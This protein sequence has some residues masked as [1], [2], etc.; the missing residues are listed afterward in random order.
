[1]ASPSGAKLYR[2][3]LRPFLRSEEGARVEQMR[4]QLIRDRRRILRQDFGAGSL[5]QGADTQ[6][7]SVASLA[8][9]ASSPRRKGE[10]LL[11]L[12]RYLRPRQALE[13]GSHLGLS[14]A[15]LKLGHPAMALI[16]I[17]GDPALGALAKEHW[18]QLD[19]GIDLRVGRFEEMLPQLPWTDFQPELVFLDGNHRYAP[20]LDYFAHLA[21]QVPVG[22]V[23]VLDD[24]HWSPEMDQAWE[25]VR[26]R[27]E[28]S[29]SLDLWQLG[30]LQLGHGPSPQHYTLW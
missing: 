15:Y 29:L 21:P 6:P 2:E 12:A 25:E 19:L 1:M 11:H 27:P 9:R 4:Q 5:N 10:R 28:V 26:H 13:L 14:A 7:V 16:S 18:Q 24:I 22:G 8:R 17:E 30:V 20:T 23:I 3:A